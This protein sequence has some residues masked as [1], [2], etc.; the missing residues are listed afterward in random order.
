MWPWKAEHALI[1]LRLRTREP[2]RAGNT[3]VMILCK[4]TA[5]GANCFPLSV[6]QLYQLPHKQLALLLVV[7]A[8]H[9]RYLLSNTDTKISWWK[10]HPGPKWPGKRGIFL[11]CM[12]LYTQDTSSQFC[13]LVPSTE[14]SQ[15]FQ[16]QERKT[17][18]EQK[19][20]LQPS[21]STGAAWRL[22]SGYRTKKCSLSFLICLQSLCNPFLHFNAESK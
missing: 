18:T 16:Q 21:P 8:A 9:T 2:V 22:D 12:Y 14:S 11:M 19:Q 7:L 4:D 15:G 13:K 5:P 17:G 20:G 3:E 10:G 1:F 6:Q